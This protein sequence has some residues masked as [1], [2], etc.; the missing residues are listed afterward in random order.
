VFVGEKALIQY[1]NDFAQTDEVVG[2]PEKL[3]KS[4]KAKA[5][6]TPCRNLRFFAMRIQMTPY[7]TESS[8]V[9]EIKSLCGRKVAPG[10]SRV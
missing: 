2:V 7:T 3:A 4:A 6:T 1:P 9:Y 5:K 8:Y 10:K